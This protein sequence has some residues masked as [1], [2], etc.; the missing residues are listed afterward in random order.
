MKNIFVSMLALLSAT[1]SLAAVNLD[2]T[3]SSNSVQALIFDAL[4]E[5]KQQD[6][7]SP[8]PSGVIKKQGASLKIDDG[9]NTLECSAKTLGAAQVE[10]YKCV[11][12]AENLSWTRS[13][14]SVQAILW[15]ALYSINQNTDRGTVTIQ[16]EKTVL[17][18]SSKSLGTA[19]VQSY[20]CTV[21]NK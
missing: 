15:E 9:M 10:S 16:D 14:D 11:L 18:C 17:A 1:S 21:T 5:M 13:S 4:W 2:W 6:A 7:A 20:R 3:R 12:S 19:A 8:F